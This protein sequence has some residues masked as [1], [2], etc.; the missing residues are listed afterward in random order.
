METLAEGLYKEN[1][2]PPEMVMDTEPEAAK[3]A[4]A[5][6]ATT[7][8]ELGRSYESKNEQDDHT[9]RTETTTLSEFLITAEEATFPRMHE[10]ATHEKTLEEEAPNLNFAKDSEC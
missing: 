1:P 9:D 3:P 7:L 6:N 5:F 2:A 8:A 10:S 4:E